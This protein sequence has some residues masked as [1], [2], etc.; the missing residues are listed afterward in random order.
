[1]L[2]VINFKYVDALKKPTATAAAAGNPVFT[3]LPP[4]QPVFQENGHG[5]ERALWV[6]TILMGISSLI[7]YILAARVPVQ[8]RLSNYLVSLITT[9]S[10]LSYYAM[11][12]NSAVG[13]SHW[14]TYVSHKEGPDVLTDVYRAAFWPRWVNWTVTSTLT[15]LILTFLSGLNGA[16]LLVLLSA[17]TIM[18][19][20]A[21]TGAIGAEEK[22][23]W[24]WFI[25]AILSYLVMFY[26]GLLN[27]RRTVA[28]KDAR[29]KNFFSLVAGS[30]Y[31]LV[32]AYP[33]VFALGP[34]SH[35]ISVNSE[36][37]IFSILDL[38]SQGLLAYWIIGG[39]TTVPALATS[40]NG[41]W[42]EGTGVE[43]AI[44]IA[45]DEDDDGEAERGYRR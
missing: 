39:Q 10:F 20:A 41:F 29:T 34:Y 22:Y 44:R 36:V 27:A 25:I 8:K 16:G 32:L 37:I 31:V 3:H 30:Y 12:T 6:I 28:G 4:V 38:L 13:Y 43:G 11:A 45:E 1:M 18:Y 17:N 24:G 9:V 35:R 2:P 21:A 40:Y 33:V 23:K 5:G 14:Q 19:V 15:L 26:Q 42:S 7:F